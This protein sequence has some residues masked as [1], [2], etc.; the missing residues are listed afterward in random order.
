MVGLQLLRAQ[1]NLKRRQDDSDGCEKRD[2]RVE[3]VAEE[4]GIGGAGVE[5]A[6]DAEFGE[7]VDQIQPAEAEFAVDVAFVD[8]I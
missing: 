4:V 1:T 2:E 7:A 3:I 8:N 6:A 5:V